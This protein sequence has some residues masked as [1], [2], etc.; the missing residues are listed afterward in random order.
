M[1]ELDKQISDIQDKIS[2]NAVIAGRE[3]TRKKYN[4]ANCDELGIDTAKLEKDGY[5]AIAE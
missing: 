1:E 4:K 5:V 2:R 3:L